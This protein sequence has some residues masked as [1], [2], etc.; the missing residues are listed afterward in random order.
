[1]DLLTKLCREHK[2]APQTAA[3]LAA[4]AA[5]LAEHLRGAGALTADKA[6][7]ELASTPLIVRLAVTDKTRSRFAVAVLFEALTAKPVKADPVKADP[8]KAEPK[9]KPEVKTGKEPDA[10][11][12]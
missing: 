11:T 4:E 12:H 8:V 5:R 10:A 2:V 6:L 7:S 3:D 1:V 9:A